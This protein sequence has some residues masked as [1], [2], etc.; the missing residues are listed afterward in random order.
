MLKIAICDDEPQIRKKLEAL[1]EK[2]FADYQAIEVDTYSKGRDIVAA[3]E[4]GK[5]YE[6]ILM[7]IDMETSDAGIQAGR[8]IKDLRY[9]QAVLIFITGYQEM[10][11]EAFLAEP[12][13]FLTKPVNESK[14]N[15]IMQ[16]ALFKISKKHYSFIYKKER[17]IDRYDYCDIMYFKCDDRKVYIYGYRNKKTVLLDSCYCSLREVEADI[18]AKNLI[19]FIR[20]NRSHIINIDYV[21]SFRLNKV[22]M[23]NGDE[24]VITKTRKKKTAMLLARYL[25][26]LGDFYGQND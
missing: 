24:M 5:T 18:E 4:D 15:E 6:I 16:K 19:N 21:K 12:F 8:E 17:S 10:L 20:F 26:D 11:E 7:D 3:I 9:G 22:L 25:G 1:L 2:S 23:E 14:F 13:Y